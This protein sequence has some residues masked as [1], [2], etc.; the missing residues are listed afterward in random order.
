MLACWGVWDALQLRHNFPGGIY[1]TKHLAS[2][3]RVPPGV[4][5][6]T[7]LGDVFKRLTSSG[8]C[9]LWMPGDKEPS[10]TLRLISAGM[11]LPLLQGLRQISTRLLLRQEETAV[12]AALVVPW[13]FT[14]SCQH[15]S[16]VLASLFSPG[17]L[18]F[19]AMTSSCSP[20]PEPKRACISSSFLCSFPRG[21]DY[22]MSLFRGP[23]CGEKVRERYRMGKCCSQ[24]KGQLQ[25]IRRMP[26][27]T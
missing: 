11:P 16:P 3:T 13:C 4:F 8:V 6:R 5:E 25:R 21:D 12:A 15:L 20:F 1:D 14:S 24:T 17:P 18:A 26:A 23:D 9:H 7:S 27:Q 22:L 19:A 2:S 10:Y